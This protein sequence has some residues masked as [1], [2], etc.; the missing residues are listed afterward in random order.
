MASTMMRVIV[1]V[2][3][4][5]MHSFHK[6]VRQMMVVGMILAVG[7]ALAFEG[8]VMD[9][10]DPYADA[11][12]W[13]K[14]DG[15]GVQTADSF[16]SVLG[17][18]KP[19]TS[20]TTYNAGI[21]SNETV[22]LP[23]RGA[24]ITAPTLYLPHPFTVTNE[25]TKAGTGMSTTVSLDNFTTGAKVTSGD[26]TLF[27]RFRPDSEQFRLDN[28]W[29]LNWGHSDNRGFMLGLYGKNALTTNEVGT[30]RI[31]FRKFRMAFY[32]SGYDNL[33]SDLDGVVW[34]EHWNDLIISFDS[35]HRKLRYVFCCE[36]WNP[37]SDLRITEQDASDNGGQRTYTG[38]RE[39]G[40]GTFTPSANLL[41]GCEVP[42]Y[43][44]FDAVLGDSSPS[45]LHT[46]TFR[47]SYHQIVTW[48]R[49]MSI[50]EMKKTLAWPRG[51]LM[52]VGVRNDKT[53]E[54]FGG[55]ATS[56]DASEWTF[57]TSFAPGDSATVTFKT[58]HVGEEELQQVF[59]GIQPRTLPL[60]RSS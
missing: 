24:V 48:N 46:K 51:D 23:Y 7:R 41:L 60:A 36:G 1:K 20:I 21:I 38:E 27:V 13:I 43:G 2:G 22:V 57:P 37:K 12:S 54:F 16:R 32:K 3:A 49:T 26:F 6:A 8:A 28:I 18:T 59:A 35:A 53:D 50:D 40:D 5:R 33:L 58:D 17:A 4:K 55:T 30:S 42:C 9:V 44:T 47:G 15:V 34:G 29:M 14:F 11:S 19:W 52:R 39:I 31:V 10:D 56:Q 45:V 25:V